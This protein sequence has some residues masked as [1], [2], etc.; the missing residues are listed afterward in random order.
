MKR[1]KAKGTAPELLVFSEMRRRGISFQRHYERAP[2][3]PDLARPRKKLAVFIDG[4]FWHG[5]DI[6]RIIERHGADSNWAS[7]LTRNMQRDSENDERLLD[8]GWNI[9]RVW[10]SDLMR[11]STRNHY[12]DAIEHFLRSKD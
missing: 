4:D 11:A 7:K 8:L 1:I 5:R 6:E 9:Y 2:G 10:S 3:K 12:L